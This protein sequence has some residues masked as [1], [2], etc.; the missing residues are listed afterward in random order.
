VATLFDREIVS[1][2]WIAAGIVV[3]AIIGAFLARRVQMTEMPEMVAVFNG[4]G[5]AASA[6]LAGGELKRLYDSGGSID[7]DVGVTIALGTAIGAVTLTGSVVAAGKLHGT[8]NSN[9]ILLPARNILSALIAVAVLALGGL[10]IWA[11][12]DDSVSQESAMLIFVGLAAA[13]L[14]LGVLV[15]IPIGGADMPVLVALFNSY[16]GLAAAAAGFAID[17]D[18]LII[19][20]ALVGASGLIL[21][22][23]MTKAMNRSVINVMFGGFGQ[24]G[25]DVTS[26]G[27]ARPYRSV[28]AEDAATMLAYAQSVVF[29]TGY[30]LAVAQAQHDLKALA[31]LLAKGGCEV[32]YGIHP[33][34]GRMPGHMNVLLAEADVPYDQL[35]DLDEA[36]R[37]LDN[38]EIA[39]VI[40]ANDVVNPQAHSNPGSPIYGMPIID[41]DKAQSVVVMKRSM[42]SGFSGIDNDLFYLDQTSMLFGDAKKSLK[43]LVSEVDEIQKS[44]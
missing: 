31:D 41:V 34:A 44:G 36:N 27:E 22:S 8:L 39:M 16:S 29:V 4:F 38:T 33:V 28:N 10:L 18:V 20:G 6:L 7:S 43:S 23:I 1:Y 30:G 40:G 15:S 35:L 13:A 26:G 14:L 32:K 11:T 2:E 25:A 21:T 12:Q 19:A 37:Q 5:G 3:G 24:S 17:N 9:P 42:A